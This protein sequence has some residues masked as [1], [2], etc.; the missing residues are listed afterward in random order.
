MQVRTV[1]ELAYL[2]QSV[3]DLSSVEVAERAVVDPAG[4]LGRLAGEGRI[5]TLALPTA[6]GS[7]PRW[8]ATELAPE[9]IAAFD[10]RDAPPLRSVPSWELSADEARRRILH[11]YLAQ[12]G[13]TTADTL[14]ARYAF[15]P[16]WLEEELAALV[17]NRQLAQGRFTPTGEPPGAQGPGAAAPAEYVDRRV[18][19]QMHRRTLTIL[20]NEVQPVAAA[21]YAGFLCRWQHLRPEQRLGGEGGL[22]RVL[23][24]LRAAALPGAV[25]ERDVLALRLTPYPASVLADLCQSGELVWVG[26]GGEGRRLRVRFLFRGEGGAFLAPPPADIGTLGEHAQAVHAF[27][28]SEGAV[29][30]ADLRAAL[31]LDE[32]AASA[33][34]WELAA[35]GLATCD[36]LAVLRDYLQYGAPGGHNA[37]P[38]SSLELDLAER[39]ARQRG[40]AAQRG[41]G[42]QPARPTF[43]GAVNRPGRSE[44]AAARRRVAARLGEGADPARTSR[45]EGR[46]TLVHRFGVL[47]KPL[48]PGEIAARQA[49]QLLAR[50][51][52][53]TH[54]SL[55]DET[56][57]WDWS[58]IYPELQRL[59]MR[60]EVRRG[61]FVR[62][63][64]GVQFALPEVVE[65]LRAEATGRRNADE[66]VVILN[67][68]DPANRYGA[69]G[70]VQTATGEPLAFA[71]IP[72]TYLAL[73]EGQPV[74]LLTDSGAHAKTMATVDAG[75]VSRALAAWVAHAAHFEP[76]VSV[77]SWNGQPVLGS[78]GQPL[79][80]AAG[81]YRDYTAMT[82]AR[83]RP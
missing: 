33:A 53:V 74:L 69:A 78:E 58:M 30:H 32:E 46:W 28:Q 8:V 2:L 21:A 26:A 80:E 48:P 63:L 18:L 41:R 25:W 42:G 22:R 5:V 81:F 59:E 37:R 73:Q 17:A 57:A 60:G 50:Y 11:R 65:Q 43:G 29:F 49:R 82:W 20:R 4:F 27:L 70:E 16:D 62:G 45:P 35:A 23:Q 13:P 72:S 10:V 79:L 56:G 24:Q 31:D 61:Y 66:P 54:A 39:L 77:V 75:Q 3:G 36:N 64:P 76:R 44:L 68:C 12:V 51:G 19:E 9:Y 52:V 40:Q 55:D 47:G 38:L 34:L 14:R 67:A 1:D 83:G 7:E 6:R 15:P 71:R